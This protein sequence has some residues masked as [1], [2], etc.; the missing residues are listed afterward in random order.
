MQNRILT[1][2]GLNPANMKSQFLL[3]LTVSS[4]IFGCSQ[5]S[6]PKF[7]ANAEEE[8]IRAVFT[9][10]QIAWNNGDIDGFMGSYWKS[11]SLQFVSSRGINHGWQ[12]ALESYKNKYPDIAAMGTLS[13]D[14]LEVTALTPEN[15]VVMG[16]YHLTRAE[17]NLEGI[18]TVIF[19][20]IKGKWVVIYDHTS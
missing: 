6:K 8:A 12:E 17:G 15:Y 1:L 4:L 18:F 5:F 2:I 9:T 11:D 16:R 3:V 7:D 14:I 13:F 19:K 10:Q 20:K